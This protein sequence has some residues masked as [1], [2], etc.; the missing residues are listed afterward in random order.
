MAPEKGAMHCISE[1]VLGKSSL[2][3]GYFYLLPDNL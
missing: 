3:T 1:E 2:I